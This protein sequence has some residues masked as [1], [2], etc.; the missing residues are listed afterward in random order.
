MPKSSKWLWV[1]GVLLSALAGFFAGGYLQRNDLLQS[2]QEQMKD[3]Q[4]KEQKIK[5]LEEQLA[6]VQHDTA[7]SGKQIADL[8]SQLEE[9]Q[10]EL[11][12]T[13]QKLAG[14][15]KEAERLAAARVA[16]A[17]AARPAPRQPD[18]PAPARTV[19]RAADPIP[20]AAKPAPARRGGEPGTYETVRATTVHEEPVNSS[21]V[22]SQIDKGTTINVVRSSGEWLEVRSKH[23]NPPGFV[24]RADVIL[25]SRAN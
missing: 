4:A 2:M 10:K 12:A 21:K 7:D 25:V 5:L 16:A 14:A 6:K 15:A 18:P 19:A 11:A 20:P 8:K 1:A 9:N 3:M 13:Q 17:Q 22:V 24:R 23:G